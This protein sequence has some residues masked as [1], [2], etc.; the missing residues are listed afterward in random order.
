MDSTQP[1]IRPP[2]VSELS[3]LTPSSVISFVC[4][5]LIPSDPGT[6]RNAVV[7]SPEPCVVKSSFGTA[8]LTDRLRNCAS[9]SWAMHSRVTPLHSGSSS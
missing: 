6:V 5:A 9:R 4:L 1:S 7:C 3:A 2:A 8:P